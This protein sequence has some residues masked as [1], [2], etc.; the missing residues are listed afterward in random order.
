MTITA[1]AQRVAKLEA[2]IPKPRLKLSLLSS[3]DL[4]KLQNHFAAMLIEE[5]AAGRLHTLPSWDHQLLDEYETPP[6]RLSARQLVRILGPKT[7]EAMGFGCAPN[8][9]VQSKSKAG[10][11]SRV[12]PHRRRKTKGGT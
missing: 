4:H 6:Q 7:Y 5:R 3:Q 12:R 2:R 11:A 9:R 10:S 1:L 8:I